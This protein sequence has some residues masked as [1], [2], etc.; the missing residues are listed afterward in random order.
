CFR[1][2]SAWHFSVSPTGF[3]MVLP[4]GRE[5]RF[6]RFLGGL[7]PSHTGG[8]TSRSYGCL[9]SL[10]DRR[11]RNPTDVRSQML[12]AVGRP[13][14]HLAPQSG[15]CRFLYRTSSCPLVGVH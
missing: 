8:R 1:L 10:S 15:C 14:R 12:G 11:Q 5:P 6:S 4:R 7:S 2:N 13:L 3:A 9:L